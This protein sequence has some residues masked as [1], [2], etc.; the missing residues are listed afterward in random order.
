MGPRGHGECVSP[1]S[2]RR[3]R[4]LRRDGRRNLLAGSVGVD[5][6]GRRVGGVRPRRIRSVPVAAATARFFVSGVRVADDPA[7]VLVGVASYFVVRR[8]ASPEAFSWHRRTCSDR[9]R[10]RS[11]R[12][13][14]NRAP[15]YPPAAHRPPRTARS[16]HFG[17]DVRE[18]IT[19][20]REYIRSFDTTT[21]HER[22]RQTPRSRQRGRRGRRNRGRGS[23]RGVTDRPR[24]VFASTSSRH[25]HEVPATLDSVRRAVTGRPPARPRTKDGTQGCRSNGLRLVHHNYYIFWR[26][27]AGYEF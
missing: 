10:G 24:P 11:P 22:S 1:P 9:R 13:I 2:S 5:S 20:L 23:E 21:G 17:P 16:R 15:L 7:A 27:I 8:H 6:S 26:R 3:R 18:C 25:A 4:R 19:V 14:E 12:P